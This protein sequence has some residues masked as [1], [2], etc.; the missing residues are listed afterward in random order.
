MNETSIG[1]RA[2]A[3]LDFDALVEGQQAALLGLARRLIW[4]PEEARDLV[5]S[6]LADAYEKRHTLRDPQAGP[7][8]LRRI[9]VSRAMS[10]LRRRRVWHVL[11]EVLDLGPEPP[12]S[13]EESFAGAER[14][15]AL[16]RELRKLPPQQAAAF[17]LRYLEGLDLDAVAEAM[18]IGRGTVRVHLH[19]ALQKLKAVDALVM[20]GE[21]P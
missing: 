7:A 8:W 20:K 15:R 1:T 14:W 13:P 2:S 19:R 21:M 18:G 5:Q 6:S 10:L 17:S 11:R 16:G 4:D 12:P 3:V 9:L